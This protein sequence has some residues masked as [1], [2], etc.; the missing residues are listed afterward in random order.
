LQHSYFYSKKEE[1]KEKIPK[2]IQNDSKN[3]FYKLINKTYQ[4][5]FIVNSFVRKLL[6][7]GSCIAFMY[8]MPISFEVFSEQQKIL[9]KIQ[10]QAM[11]DETMGGGM[12]PPTMRPF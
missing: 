11:L 10:M 5:F 3:K 6:W 2:L 1:K 9:Q 4:L 8:I 12:G 7:F